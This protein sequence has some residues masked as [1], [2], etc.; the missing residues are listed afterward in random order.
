[1][2]ITDLT[3]LDK[4][5]INDMQL[6]SFIGFFPH[7]KKNKQ[8]VLLNIEI[9]YAPNLLQGND[10]PAVC[11]D[12]QK[13]CDQIKTLLNDSMINLLETMAEK[14]AALILLFDQR[15]AATKIRIDKPQALADCRSSAIEIVRWQ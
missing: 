8:P 14:V 1:M 7:E 9:Y 5:I 11:I 3:Q 10:N 4:L 12:Y 2:R 15:I 6:N 13:I